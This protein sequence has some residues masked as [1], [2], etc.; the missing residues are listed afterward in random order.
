MIHFLN[1]QHNHIF[2]FFSL[3]VYFFS[4]FS[5]IER[6]EITMFVLYIVVIYVQL[7]WCGM[8]GNDVTMKCEEKTLNN[9]TEEI[10]FYFKTSCLVTFSC[11]HD[12]FH[13]ILTCEYGFLSNFHASARTIFLVRFNIIDLYNIIVHNSLT[14]NGIFQSVD[15]ESRF[16]YLSLKFIC[17]IL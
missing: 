12:W 5:F 3:L 7:M 1:I 10:F 17:A 16:E 2:W 11:I 13:L 14:F 6:N 9:C 15:Q 4:F 8:N